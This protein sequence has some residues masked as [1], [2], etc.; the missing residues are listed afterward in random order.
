MIALYAFLLL[1]AIIWFYIVVN[2]AVDEYLWIKSFKSA[3][4]EN[5]ITLEDFEGQMFRKLLIF[6]FPHG[7]ILCAL[8]TDLDGKPINIELPNRYH[9]YQKVFPSFF[10]RGGIRGLTEQSAVMHKL[11]KNN[12]GFDGVSMSG[13]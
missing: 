9:Q 12:I 4:D 7:G 8:V 5:K 1:Y 2:H 10:R 6:K 3:W 13:P 11:T